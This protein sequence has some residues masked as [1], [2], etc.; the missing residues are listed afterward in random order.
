M[1]RRF[2]RDTEPAMH[3][4]RLIVLILL[5]FYAAS[6][7]AAEPRFSGS[8]ALAK[9]TEST[10]SADGRFSI[11]GDLRPAAMTQSTGRFALNAKLQPDANSIA[12]AC[13]LVSDLIFRNGFE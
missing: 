1:N 13:D 10:A 5:T 9:P 4:P 11:N 12:T 3:Q 2:W 7:S 8:A 6:A